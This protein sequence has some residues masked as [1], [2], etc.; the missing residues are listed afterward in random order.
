MSLGKGKHV[1]TMLRL[2]E[3][4]ANLELKFPAI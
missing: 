3:I 4:I 2:K 1:A